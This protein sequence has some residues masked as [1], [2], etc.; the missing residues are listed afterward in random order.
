[1]INT[2][3]K[4]DKIGFILKESFSKKS[5]CKWVKPSPK[6][7]QKFWDEIFSDIIFVNFCLD[8]LKFSK[9]KLLKIV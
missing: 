3:K 6:V 8:I 7:E 5:G 1:M 4:D 2:K 9:L